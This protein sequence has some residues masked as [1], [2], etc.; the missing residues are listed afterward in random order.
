MRLID[1]EELIMHLNDW[2]LTIAPTHMD[3]EEDYALKTEKYQLLSEVID[4]IV[5]SPT[6]TDGPRNDVEKH[7]QKRY[8]ELHDEACR[9]Q[10]INDP[11]AWALYQVWREFDEKRKKR[12]NE[13]Y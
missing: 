13:A 5:G 7:I 1:A 9:N 4:V 2:A 6:M 3:N 8:H 10:T 12:Q 11:V